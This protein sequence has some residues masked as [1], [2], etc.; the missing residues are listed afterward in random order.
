MA[1][2]DYSIQPGETP[3]SVER[4]RKL[5]EAMMQEGAN[6]SPIRSP[7]Q[8]L[9]RVAQGLVGG[10]EAGQ[11]DKTEATKQNQAQQRIAAALQSNDP[12]VQ[13][14]ALADPWA[15]E[16]SRQAI[17]LLSQRQQHI[18]DKAQEQRNADREF[19]L[20]QQVANEPQWAVIGQ[21]PN[22]GAPMYGKVPKGNGMPTP[23]NP[24]GPAKPLTD[25]EGNPI[26]LPPGSNPSIARDAQ[27]KIN[28]EAIN[29]APQLIQ[30]AQIDLQ[31]I[32]K[33]RNHPGKYWGTGFTGS[34]P[35]IAGTAKKDFDVALDQVRNGTF[36]Q[37][38][39]T[40]RGSGAI[41]NA[42]GEKAQ[43]AVARLAQAQSTDAFDEA[44]KDY[45][46]VIRVG[47]E[48]AQRIQQRARGTTAPTVDPVEAEMRRR[49]LK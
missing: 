36:L 21:D 4:R 33:L 5:A 49:G 41:S 7:W 24:G 19:Q 2:Q 45:E 31:N 11:A 39:K 9:A 42:E 28:V 34:L 12:M 18:A 29:A 23:Y 26:S 32:D 38:Y 37:A 43:N 27:T 48:R 40:L 20:R 25:A 44:L 15:P 35:S 16:G 47:M 14:Q 22:T 46:D 8:G 30:G 17:G 6:Y 10:Y 13:S 3:Q 1:I